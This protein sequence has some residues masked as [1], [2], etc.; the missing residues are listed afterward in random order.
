MQV[1]ETGQGERLS[2]RATDVFVVLLGAYHDTLINLRYRGVSSFDLAGLSV[3]KG[4][5][6]W[7]YD[8]FRV[9]ESGALVHEIEWW[10]QDEVAHWTIECED[11]EFAAH[12]HRTAS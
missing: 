7:R 4:H 2:E 5:G 3:N 6:D 1:V 8:E 11:I 9:A 12:P 10:S